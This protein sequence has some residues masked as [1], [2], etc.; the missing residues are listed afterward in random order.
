MDAIGTETNL[1]AAKFV[2]M[3]SCLLSWKDNI[4]EVSV[5]CFAI[6]K[7]MGMHQSQ[8]LTQNK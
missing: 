4:H 2:D 8:F 1:Y 3:H 7:L 5:F 6:Q